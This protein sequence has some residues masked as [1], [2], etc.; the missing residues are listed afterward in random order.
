MK[1]QILS[2]YADRDS[3]RHL[4]LDAVTDKKPD[5]H[6]RLESKVNDAMKD[7]WKPQGGI[8]ADWQGF[9]CQAMIKE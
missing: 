9:L 1:Y 2:A 4:E 3:V 5:M 6:S 8:T 7:G